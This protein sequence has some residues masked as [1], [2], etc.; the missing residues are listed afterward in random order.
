MVSREIRIAEGH[1]NLFV[2][3]ERLHCRQVHPCP[4]KA[5][6]KRMSQVMKCKV[7]NTGLCHGTFKRGPKVLVRGALWRAEH[8]TVFSVRSHSTCLQCGKQH[9]VHWHAA[10][11]PVLGIG[12]SDGD[13]AR[14]EV[15]IRPGRDNSPDTRNP[16][17]RAVI[18]K[19][20][21]G[22]L[23]LSSKQASSCGV[24]IR[25]RPLLSRANRTF[26]TGLS[27]ALPHVIA[28]VYWRRSWTPDRGGLPRIGLGVG[29]MQ[30][31]ILRIRLDQLR[32][33]CDDQQVFGVHRLGSLGEIE[34]VGNNRGGVND[35]HLI[36]GDSVLGINAGRNTRIDQEGGS[37][38]FVGLIRLLED[39]L[40][41]A[42]ALGVSKA[43]TA[44]A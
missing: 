13:D 38:V 12:R 35:H 3:H 29:G 7:R 17:W 6:S 16:L 39:R 44:A 22:G 23:Q 20:V 18:T 14:R 24:R 11:L 8:R 2:S 25:I 4:H 40:H 15:H 43:R 36:V 31:H 42:A 5:T 30:Q 19:G 1:G 32:C 37:A 33:V 26:F 27:V 9:I 21:S 10:A 34:R 41:A 28:M